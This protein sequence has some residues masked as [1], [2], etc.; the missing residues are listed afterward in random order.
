MK[1]DITLKSKTNFEL[2]KMILENKKEL[3][4]LRFQKKSASLTNTS[5]F[6]FVKK[7]IARI[8]TILSSRNNLNKSGDKAHA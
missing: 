5:R 8:S 7:T 2:E 1:K 4:N 3:M 6:K